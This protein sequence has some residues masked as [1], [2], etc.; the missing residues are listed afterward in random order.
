[1][2]SFEPLIDMGNKSD[3]ELLKAIQSGDD[4]AFKNVFDV[5]WK[6][7]YSVVMNLVGD[8][9]HT[10]DILQNTFITFWNKR[11]S[12][13]IADSLWPYLIKIA[14]NDVID[15]F[16]KNKVRL[17]GAELLINDLQYYDT[18]EE[19]M[20]SRELQT[21]IDSEIVNMPLNMKLCFELSR[22]EEKSIREIASELR[23]SEQTV[24]NN[25]SEA[26]KRL[27]Q[28]VKLT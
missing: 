2:A 15:Q 20:I 14:R 9:D 21:V 27:R 19:V 23:L 22:H 10:K 7:L 26:L 16:R 11:N 25:I 1:L 28:R 18:V 5:Y 4:E 13:I 8:E 6:R 17:E 12:L 3:I 24:K